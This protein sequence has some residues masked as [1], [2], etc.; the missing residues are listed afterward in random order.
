MG[1]RA[2]IINQLKQ[3]IVELAKKKYD[4]IK[5][6][7]QVEAKETACREKL[8]KYGAYKNDPGNGQGIEELGKN[9]CSPDD[10]FSDDHYVVRMQHTIQND[11]IN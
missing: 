10:D 8:I 6:I 7:W 5:Q 11:T 4:L 9:C 1:A 2:K 3:E